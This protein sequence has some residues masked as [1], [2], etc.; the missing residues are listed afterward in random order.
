MSRPITPVDDKLGAWLSAAL[1]DENASHEFKAAVQE[2]FASFNQPE[3][4]DRRIACPFCGRLFH[5]RD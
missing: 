3:K 4:R 2:W 5:L 1:D